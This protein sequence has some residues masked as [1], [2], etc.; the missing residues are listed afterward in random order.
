MSLPGVTISV[1]FRRPIVNHQT[2]PK[3]PPVI[4]LIWSAT[5]PNVEACKEVLRAAI[6]RVD[7]GVLGWREWAVGQH[8][9]P[10]YA[11]GYGSPTVLVNGRDV[12][13]ASPTSFSDYCGLYATMYTV[14]GV[15]LVEEV[16]EAIL[17]SF[18]AERCSSA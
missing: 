7:C 5:C 12:V 9:T 10:P 1:V 18:T 8:G 17:T 2:T 15:P 3:T 4:D 6:E 11:E 13:D 14:R 16:V